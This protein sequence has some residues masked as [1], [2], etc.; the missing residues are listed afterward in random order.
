MQARNSRRRLLVHISGACVALA[1]TAC[2]TADNPYA[3]LEDPPLVQGSLHVVTLVADTDAPARNIVD[4]G[5]TPAPLPPNYPQA[6]AVEASI[7]GVP[8]PVA[9]AVQHFKAPAGKTDVRLLVMPLAARGR[10]A[11]ADVNRAFFRNVLGADV[12]TWPLS[13][14]A[15]DSVRV[16][17]WTY[18]VPDI[19]NASKR[20]RESGVPVIYDP[21]GIT[22]SYLG[23]HRT[24]AIRAPDGTVV[25][26]VQNSTR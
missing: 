1:L 8:E 3:K 26:L 6:T 16:Q 21:V 13:R 23:D 25:Q 11:K 14:P 19:V 10:E 24:L 17:V 20:L 12:P 2:G 18:F 15:D 9:A 4:D 22:T 7:W 5:F